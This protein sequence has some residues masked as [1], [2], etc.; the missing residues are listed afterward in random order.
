MQNS[1][2]F[3][4]KRKCVCAD[5]KAPV[6][7]VFKEKKCLCLSQRTSVQKLPLCYIQKEHVCVVMSKDRRAKFY[8]CYI[9][10]KH[11]FVLISKYR[12][13]KFAMRFIQGENVFVLM[14][15]H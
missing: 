10:G 2:L 6:S 14:C 4:S 9:Q 7:A 15:K 13:A 11:A 8:L 1:D 3:Y 5:V 12:C